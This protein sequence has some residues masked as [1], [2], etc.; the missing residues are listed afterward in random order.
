MVVYLRTHCV[1]C[2]KISLLDALYRSKRPRGLRRRYEA[3]RLLRL[4]VRIPPKLCMF[5]CFECCG[6]SGTGLYEEL[7]NSSRG[8]PLSVVLRCDLEPPRM[9]PW[10]ALGRSATA[11]R[12]RERERERETGGPMVHGTRVAH[13]ITN[14]ARG[15]ILRTTDCKY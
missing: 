10:T 7:M 8:V 1:R 12:E 3:A 9:K 4:W 5:V 11:E 2:L 6:L 14:M 13:W 15:V